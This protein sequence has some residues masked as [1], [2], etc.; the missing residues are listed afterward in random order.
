MRRT[1]LQEIKRGATLK[2]DK[3]YTIDKEFCGYPGARYVLR[4]CGAWVSQ[5]RE[6]SDAQKAVKTHEEAR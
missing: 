3:R 1:L 4:F 2:T 6:L 5:H